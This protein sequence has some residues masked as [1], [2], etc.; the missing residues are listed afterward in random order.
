MNAVLQ[1]NH[2]QS[3]R[4]KHIK[5]VNA[6]QYKTDQRDRTQDMATKLHLIPRFSWNNDD[7]AATVIEIVRFFIRML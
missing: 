7:A 5:D 3:D 2:T 4:N 6:S 1:M